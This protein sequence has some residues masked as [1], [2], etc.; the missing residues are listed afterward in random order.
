MDADVL[1]RAVLFVL[2]VLDPAN[3]ANP[4]IPLSLPLPLSLS[5]P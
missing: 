2:L 5:L 3:S 1:D 4:G